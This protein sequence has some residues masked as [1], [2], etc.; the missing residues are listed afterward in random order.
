ME[1]FVVVIT[2][3]RYVHAN[4][5]ENLLGACAI[6]ILTLF[7]WLTCI[8]EIDNSTGVQINVVI[9]MMIEF[10]ILLL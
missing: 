8:C 9:I 7:V 6:V 10:V 5:I 3:I 2:T 4:S 1:F